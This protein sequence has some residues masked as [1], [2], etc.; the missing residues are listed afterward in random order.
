VPL[1]GVD[2]PITWP[3]GVIGGGRGRPV[4]KVG[5]QQ[6]CSDDS[7]GEN[8][9][10]SLELAF[11]GPHEH[12]DGDGMLPSRDD[13]SFIATMMTMMMMTN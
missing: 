6:Y 9:T 3:R 10:E 1:H 11:H 4:H 7:D 2:R 12:C 8:S 13:Q 5:G